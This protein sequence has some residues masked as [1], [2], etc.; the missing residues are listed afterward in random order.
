MLTVA[1][2]ELLVNVIKAPDKEGLFS[3]KEEAAISIIASS[4][5]YIEAS[6]F[7]KP[8]ISPSEI[9]SVIDITCSLK[10]PEVLDI[11]ELLAIRWSLELIDLFA[12]YLSYIPTP[13]IDGL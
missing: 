6:P 12:I 11:V 7:T 3:G 1:V 8:S 4:F 10:L 13:V 9:K 2:E 5:K